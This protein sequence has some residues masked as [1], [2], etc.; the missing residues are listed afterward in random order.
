[1]VAEAMALLL[2]M[3][4]GIALLPMAWLLPVRPNEGPLPD[5]DDQQQAIAVKV[6][7]A[8]RAAARR[9]PIVMV[10][11]PK[12]L[13]ARVML[14][15]RKVPCV[16]HLGVRSLSGDSGRVLSGHAWL[17]V[18]PIGVCGLRDAAGHTEVTRYF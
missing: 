8:I 16:L 18:G 7:R 11:L 1:M 2:V 3:R 5:P 9:L 12:A 13:T 4:L 17:T 6:A 10:C 15:R 14:R